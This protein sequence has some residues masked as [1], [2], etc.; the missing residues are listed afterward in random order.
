MFMRWIIS[1]LFIEGGAA[2]ASWYFVCVYTS[3]LPYAF[4]SVCS[5]CVYVHECVCLCKHVCNTSSGPLPV[6]E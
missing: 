2:G 5:V 3:A 4:V 6:C 1:R